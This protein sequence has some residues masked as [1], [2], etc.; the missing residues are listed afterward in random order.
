VLL[1]GLVMDLYQNYLMMHAIRG[2]RYA[3]KEDFFADETL[4][5]L[6]LLLYWIRIK[7]SIV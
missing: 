7:Y 2:S 4:D 3:T 5:H 1:L 6:G